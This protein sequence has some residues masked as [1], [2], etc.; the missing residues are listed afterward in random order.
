MKHRLL[1]TAAACITTALV[2]AACGGTTQH[3]GGGLGESGA[4]HITS[5][6]LAYV[7]VDTDLGSSQWQKLDALLKKFPVRARLLTELKGALADKQLDYDRDVKPALGPELDLAVQAGS[8][9]QDIAYAYLWK[10]DSM[11]KAKALVGKLDQSSPPSATR[12]VDGWLFVADKQEMIDR[13][14]NTSGASLAGDGK[15]KEAMGR[16]PD[17]AL[18]K[19]YA[20]GGRLSDLVDAIFGGSA[21]TTAGGSSR[22][23]LDKLDWLAGALAAKDDGLGL[24]GDIKGTDGTP[25]A[26]QEYESKL[27]SGVPA[28]AIAFVSFHGK[29][30]FDPF[31][32]ARQNPAFGQGLRQVEGMLGMSLDQVFAL[33]E[34][35]TAFY[36]RRGPGLP[37]FS[38]VLE[39]PDTQQALTTIDRLANRAAALTHA[40]IGTDKEGGLDV[41]TLTY[42]PVT[43][44]WAGF[45]GRVLLTT[46]PTGIRDYRA[47]GDKL[48]DDA[49]FKDALD[50]AGASGKNGGLVYVNLAD[51]VQL[52]QNYAGLAN[53]RLPADVRENLKP[54]RSFVAYGTSSGDVTKLGAFLAVK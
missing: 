50:A 42:G 23:G 51:A 8:S 18:V 41:K 25:F 29:P 14:L 15:F 32:Q 3:S 19:A 45:D 2:A 6:A 10:P 7:A 40:R 46:A 49:T 22:F 38:L 5:G 28:D 47:S 54:L 34:H 43:L 44:H 39:A 20:N 37:E 4:S 21:Q 36:V 1:A 16:L 17:D 11:A 53:G 27:I 12:V 31:S 48:G 35:E 52:I 33:F 30:G 24:E 26:L 9:A 13:V